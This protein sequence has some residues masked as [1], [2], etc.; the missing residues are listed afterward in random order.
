MNK[1]DELFGD[2]AAEVL[3]AEKKFSNWPESPYVALCVLGEEYGELQKAV[4]HVT[5]KGADVE[6][7]RSEAVQVAAM[8]MR[9][10]L[11]LD[12]YVYNEDGQ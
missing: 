8:A 3:R 10:L 2:V 4:L 1:V 5:E 7:V 12:E 9:F 6:D 11:G